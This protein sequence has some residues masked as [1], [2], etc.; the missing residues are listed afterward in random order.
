MIR[1]KHITSQ[2]LNELVGA[3]F[4][5]K[6][7]FVGLMNEIRR[8]PNEIPC[9]SG[10]VPSMRIPFLSGE[11]KAEWGFTAGMSCLTQK[12]DKSINVQNAEHFP[13]CAVLALLSLLYDAGAADGKRITITL[14]IPE[15]PGIEE[16]NTLLREAEALLRT[17]TIN[18]VS[19]AAQV[20]RK[21][22]SSRT[23]LLPSN[24]ICV[25]QLLKQ[26]DVGRFVAKVNCINGTLHVGD[27]VTIADGNFQVLQ[28]HCPVTLIAS[29]D[30]R[31]V[32]SSDELDEDVFF[33]CFAMW[34]PPNT[35]AFNGMN[36]IKEETVPGFTPRE[37]PGPVTLSESKQ[38]PGF[39]RRLF[40]RTDD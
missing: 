11:E 18:R 1:V 19:V 35:P 9:E 34:F 38:K 24:S 30:N 31:T 37:M 2:Q 27:D 6:L 8:Y 20:E 29:Q 40:H 32:Q 3:Q 23:A 5:A 13:S 12:S 28:E 26:T 22:E 7:W 10:E 14:R 17:V 39:F 16:F 21:P 25:V 33:V 4:G 15:S 36:L